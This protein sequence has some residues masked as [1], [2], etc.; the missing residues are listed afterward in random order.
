MDYNGN[1]IK[2]SIDLAQDVK[3]KAEEDETIKVSFNVPERQVTLSNFGKEASMVT[4]VTKI[5]ETIEKLR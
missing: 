1:K 5:N 3:V 2:Y 4:W